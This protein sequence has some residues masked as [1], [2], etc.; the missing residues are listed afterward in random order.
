MDLNAAVIT[1]F[2]RQIALPEIGPD[3]QSRLGDACVAVVG[4][5]GDLT[6]EIAARYLAAAGVGTLRVVGGDA[7]ADA[8][9]DVDVDVDAALRA[10]SPDV[11]IEHRAW[12]EAGEATGAAWLEALTG[13][14]LI[15]RAGFDDD[16]MLRVAIRLGIPAVVARARAGGVDVVSFRRHGPCPHTELDVPTLAGDAAHTGAE[17]VVAGAVAAA[18]ALTTLLDHGGAARA[19]VLRLPTDGGDATTQQIP[20]TPECF[21]C[22]GTGT[23]MSFQ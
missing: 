2:S 22:G 5:A 21:A 7:A 14:D 18:E 12:P 13:A 16:A 20:W 4:R 6:A 9:L 23:V 15:V 3:G 10:S 19:R 1:R 8:D 11:A 17:S